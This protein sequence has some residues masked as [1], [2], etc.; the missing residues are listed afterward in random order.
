MSSNRSAPTTEAAAPAADV[1]GVSALEPA[2]RIRRRFARTWG[3]M[4]AAWGVPNSTAAV[5]GYLLVHGGPLTKSEIQAAL[6]LSHR[7]T[8]LAIA[9]CET[10]GIIQR[11]LEQRRGGRRGPATTGWLPVNEHWE[12]FRRVAGARKER[13][14]DPVVALLR[15]AV[16][17]AAALGPRDPSAVEMREQMDSL[18]TFVERFDRSLDAVVRADSA[19]LERLFAVLARLDDRSLDRLLSLLAAL[20]EDTLARAATNVSR[21][22]PTILRRFVGLA[23]QPGLGRLI[24]R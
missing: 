6:G 15:G 12:W 1:P 8:L 5:Q 11:A 18:L 10:W 2:E 23:G 3:R 20:P 16:A 14:A 22:P 13:E 21:L 17:E 9:E 7:G 4:G 19:A 24:G